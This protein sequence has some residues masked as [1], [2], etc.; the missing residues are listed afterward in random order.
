MEQ[1]TSSTNGET[2]KSPCE[3]NNNKNDEMQETPNR[4]LSPKPSLKKT[5]TSEYPTLLMFPYKKFK[6]IS[7]SQ[8]ENYQSP[9]NTIYPIQEEKEEDLDSFEGS[10]QEG[11][12][13]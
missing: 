3:S 1:P 5:K 10:S 7:S 9:G 6:K 2:R 13:D 12:E 4:D 11:G 8:V